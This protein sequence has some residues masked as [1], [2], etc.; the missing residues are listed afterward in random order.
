MVYRLGAGLMGLGFVV[1]GIFGLFDTIGFFDT[2]NNTVWGLNSNGALSALSIVVGALLAVGVVIGGNFAS[3]LILVLGVLFVL[4]GFFNLAVLRTSVNFLD[5]R[6]QNVIFSFAIGVVL[7]TIGMYGR[8]SGNLPHDNPYWRARHPDA[9]RDEL[10]R[11]RLNET[12]G[13]A[14]KQ[15]RGGRD[16]RSGPQGRDDRGAPGTPAGSPRRSGRRANAE[17]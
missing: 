6:M 13:R 16:G 8:I 14:I 3:N 11:R 12:R 2:G 4:S 5:F 15:V 17:R 9:L 7:L 10:R 1:F